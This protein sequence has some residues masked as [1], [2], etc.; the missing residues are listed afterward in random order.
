MEGREEGKAMSR[1]LFAAICGWILFR[2][3]KRW[4]RIVSVV[5]VATVTFGL[6]FPPPAYAQFGL[7]GG[8]ENILNII[9]G[10]IRSA[11]NT[12]RAVSGAIDALH[13]Q[14]VWPVHLI[15]QARSAIASL[16]AQSLGLLESIYAAPV[17]SA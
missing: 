1:M 4:Q 12:V 3:T 8:I 11:L 13:Q 15:N 17:T 16:I 9:N 6:V 2:Y 5:L 14:I 10:A 7:L